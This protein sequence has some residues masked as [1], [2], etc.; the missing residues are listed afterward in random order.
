[1][2]ESDDGFAGYDY[3][4]LI[5][6]WGLGDEDTR[7]GNAI[8]DMME[9]GVMPN[10]AEKQDQATIALIVRHILDNCT[11]DENGDCTLAENVKSDM[12]GL[13]HALRANEWACESLIQMC[14]ALEIL[15]GYDDHHGFVRWFCH[16]LPML[17]V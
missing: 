5:Q 17:W 4:E 13:I 15:S 8:Y 12:I 16:C 1:M 14:I 3:E 10:W 11:Y 2:I 7:L 6:R 9:L